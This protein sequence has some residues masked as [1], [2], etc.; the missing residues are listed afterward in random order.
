MKSPSPRKAC[1]KP[2][3]PS[4]QPSPADA[5]RM[6]Q[7]FRDLIAQAGDKPQPTSKATWKKGPTHAGT[8][9]GT[10]LATFVVDGKQILLVLQTEEP[11]TPD[12]LSERQ[13]AIVRLVAEGLPNKAIANVLGISKWTVGTHLRHVFRKLHVNSRSAM[14]AKLMGKLGCQA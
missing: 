12:Q 2:G 8:G 13:R 14:V 5:D 11:F 9:Q 6:T 1:P 7:F 3:K 4:A 10:V